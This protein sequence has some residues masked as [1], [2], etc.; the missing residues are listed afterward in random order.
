MEIVFASGNINKFNQIALILDK[1]TIK[2]PKD[3]G[4]EGFEVEENG[5]TLKENAY[6]KAKALFDKISKPSF[7][8]D[9]GLFVE[10][11]SNRP[12]VHSHRYASENPTYRDNRKKLLEEMDGRDNRKA[13]FET[14]ICYIDKNG[15]D[16]YFHGKLTGSITKEELGDYDFG[17]DQ[18]FLPDNE[19]RTLGQMTDE[20]INQISHRAR[21]INE[22]KK[23]LEDTYDTNT[24]N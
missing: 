17:Y 16:H 15:D 19:K 14:V 2:T 11:L 20:E 1:F 13:Y 18:I 12:G 4:I 24:S 3:F 7:A 10:A 9:T 21:A 5:Q 23:F 8:D 22:F 6:I